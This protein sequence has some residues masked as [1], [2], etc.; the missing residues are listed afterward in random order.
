MEAVSSVNFD[1]SHK[2]EVLKP[3]LKWF[4]DQIYFSLIQMYEKII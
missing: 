4:Q 2:R 3:I 1:L